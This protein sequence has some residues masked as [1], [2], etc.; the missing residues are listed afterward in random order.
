MLKL[1]AVIFAILSF[2]VPAASQSQTSSPVWFT[3]SAQEGQTVT[4]TGSITLRFGQVASTCAYAESTGPC[5]AGVGAPSPEAWTTPQTFNATSSTAA[6]SILI[7]AAAFGGVDP[8]PGVYKTV[9]VQEQSTPQNITV[10]G[11][12][13][14]VPALSTSST[15]VWFTLSA[16]EGQTVTATGSI[17]L[18][19]GQVASTCAYAESTGPCTA[20]VGAP[21]PEAWTTPQTFNATSSTAAVSILIGA[22]AFGG[23]DP[24]P[25]VYKTVQVQ[26]QSTPQNITVNGQPVTVPALST[27]STPVWFTLSAQEGQTVTATGSIT[28]RFGQVA[29]TCA[30]AES[31]GPCTAGVGAPSPEAW[32]TPQTFNATSSTA[33][34]SILIGAAAFGGVDPLPGVYKTVQVQE[35]STPQNITVNGQPVT[36]PALSTSYTCQLLGTPASIAFTN[37]TVG[38]MI[39]SPASITSNCTTT[40]TVNSAVS[41]GPPFSISGLQTPFTLT[42]G[43]PQSYTAVFTPTT[44]GTATGSIA[45]TSSQSSVQPLSVSLSGAGV[46]S[47]QGTLSPSITPLSF[48]S[49]TVNSTQSQTVTITNTGA[50][51]VNVSAVGVTGTGFS[52]I[53][54]T[55]P[56]TIPVNQSVQLTVGFNPAA[57]GSASGNLTITSNASN[58]TLLVPLTGTGVTHVV[59]LTWSDSGTQIAGYNVYRSTVSGGPYSRINTTLAT[60][61]NYSDSSV[62]SGTTYF[63]TATAVGTDG[64]ESAFS[65]EAAV[66]VP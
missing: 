19:F 4:A 22:A 61:T 52:L 66:T 28:L 14:T 64:M 27:S 31:T 45:F 43:Q 29:S 49:V 53:P 13:V 11:Q 42:P 59:T 15:P 40:V 37:T 26:E 23:V 57:N 25:G 34:V 20:G 6:V 2:I 51:S 55:T 63:Y 41:S 62:V 7:G 9:Q 46:A 21:S 8:L 48:G 18:R 32:T 58:G 44:T 16:Q 5:T 1:S 10:N 56:F 47:Q 50:A 12:P 36:V 38:F 60:S 24:L 30:Y 54:V 65:N 39:S 17:T 33:A 3:L 35:Q